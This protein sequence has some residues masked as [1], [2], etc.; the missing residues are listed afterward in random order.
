M[1]M[2]SIN[3]SRHDGIVLETGF[4]PYYKVGPEVLLATKGCD[5]LLLSNLM[6]EHPLPI[7]YAD[8]PSPPVFNKAKNSTLG[9][10]AH[11]FIVGMVPSMSSAL[12]AFTHVPYTLPLGLPF[13]IEFVNG[14]LALAIAPHENKKLNKMVGYAMLS[15][16]WTAAGF[17][18]A[19]TAQKVDDFIAPALQEK[20]GRKP[21]IA[22]RYGA[23]HA[24]LIPLLS[25]R[26]IRNAIMAVHKKDW[27]VDRQ[28]VTRV[29]EINFDGEPLQLGPIVWQKEEE[30]SVGPIN[31][32]YQHLIYD[33]GLSGDEQ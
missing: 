3:L 17:R 23:G 28:Y 32:K 27:L 16:F 10:F 12:L 25:H 13:A 4:D 19:A 7:F 22:L 1:S 15:N 9:Y 18:S 26:R 29:S 8:L 33:V 24:D 6:L 20:L 14:A 21:S 30:A 31:Y 11:V 5:M 2:A